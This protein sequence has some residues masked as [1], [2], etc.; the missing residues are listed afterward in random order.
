[1]VWPFCVFQALLHRSATMVIYAQ[2]AVRR[3]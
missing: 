3:A 1:M 2:K